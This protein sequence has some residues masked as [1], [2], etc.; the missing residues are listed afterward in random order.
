MILTD[1][2]GTYRDLWHYPGIF[3]EGLSQDIPSPYQDLNSGSLESYATHQTVCRIKFS[4]IKKYEIGW[5]LLSQG[6]LHLFRC[7]PP[8]HVGITEKY[9][10]VSHETPCSSVEILRR[11]GETYWSQFQGRREQLRFPHRLVNFY[12]TRRRYNPE[13]SAYSPCSSL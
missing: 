1:S 9:S 13:D 8:V 5:T 4:I 10:N 11:F 12:R 6:K 7:V 3:L 2:Q